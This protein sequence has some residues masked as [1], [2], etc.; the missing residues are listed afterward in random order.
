MW[1]IPGKTWIETAAFPNE[2]LANETPVKKDVQNGYKYS[3]RCNLKQNSIQPDNISE[4]SH[5]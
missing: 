2:Y 4:L 3:L 5:W 1:Q